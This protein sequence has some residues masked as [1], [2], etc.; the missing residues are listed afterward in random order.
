MANFCY[1]CTIEY[2]GA[3]VEEAHQNDFHSMITK[4]EVERG[5]L[6]PVLCEGCGHIMVDHEGKKVKTVDEAIQEINICQNCL[7]NE[8]KWEFR[9]KRQAE[10]IRELEQKAKEL[11]QKIREIRNHE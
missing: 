6:L 11:R 4:S 2:F 5:F 7:R 8:R 3:K 9:Y 1:D 10:R